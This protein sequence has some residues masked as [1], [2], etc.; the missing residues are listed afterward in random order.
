MPLLYSASIISIIVLFHRLKAI[1][2]G[3]YHEGISTRCAYTGGDRQL[4]RMNNCTDLQ[5]YNGMRGKVWIWI[6][7]GF[8]VSKFWINVSGGFGLRHWTANLDWS[9]PIGV[10]SGRNFNSTRKN[11]A[12]NPPNR[13]N[14]DRFF[15]SCKK[16]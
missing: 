13:Y 1:S 3:I 2:E 15:Y 4:C 12:S 10:T 8:I 9:T 7:F 6:N 14:V 16:V 11:F 5:H